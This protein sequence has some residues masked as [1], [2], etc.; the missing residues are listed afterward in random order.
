VA[1]RVDVRL[2][3]SSAI[4]ISPSLAKTQDMDNFFALEINK[5][6]RNTNNM[7]QQSII[8]SNKDENRLEV[9]L[10]KSSLPS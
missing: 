2:L 4:D 6:R 3:S 9:Y 10:Q 5:R 1:N 7:T 8:S